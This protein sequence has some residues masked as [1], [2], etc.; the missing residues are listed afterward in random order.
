MSELKKA[1]EATGIAIRKYDATKARPIITDKGA[2]TIPKFTTDLVSA[3]GT[4]LMNHPAVVGAINSPSVMTQLIEDYVEGEGL[5]SKDSSGQISVPSSMAHLTLNIDRSSTEPGAK[6]FF[7][8]TQEEL[9]DQETSGQFYLD[10]CGAS[11][12][13]GVR[14]ARAVVPRYMP[15]R[16]RGTFIERHPVTGAQYTHFNT[17]VPSEWELWKLR[18][19]REWNKLPAKPPEEII[20]FLKHLIPS[21][22]ERE[23]LYA[24]IY[25]SM[26]SRSFVYLVLQG[27]PGV[28]K[29]RLNVLLRALHGK[30]NSVSGKKETFGA[31]DSRFNNQMLNNTMLWLD[32]LKYGPDMEPRMKEYQ[33]PYIAIERKG[34]DASS[35]TEIYSSMVISN[36][37]PRDNYILFN[38]RKFAPLVLGSQALTSSMT[39]EE[40]TR[41]SERMDNTFHTFDVKYVAQI[42]KWILHVGPKHVSKWPNLEY[43]GPKFW[44]LAHSSMSRWQKIAVLSLTTQTRSGMFAGWNPEKKAFLWSKVEEGLRRK[45]EYEAKDYR[46]ASTVKSFFDN[47]C[48]EKGVRIFETEEVPGSIIQ[49]FWVRP[50]VEPKPTEKSSSSVGGEKKEISEKNLKSDP[51]EKLKR[52]PGISSFHW[53]KMKYE[54]ELMQKGKISETKKEQSDL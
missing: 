47:Y 41:M 40:I 16:K 50:I 31:N 54:Y 48:D 27:S 22:V 4:G 6:R 34:I 19:P 12:S 8:T 45:K 17:Y 38:S 33:N 1:L 42:A 37:Y 29:N 53:R 21:K 30:S 10:S 5:A 26:T 3:L 32:E 51:T 52:P 11:I 18:N 39:P 9:M 46:D 35:S 24:W 23:Y 28:G 7:C 20:R 13:D 36:N 14:L 2:V 44:E 43:Q 49:D 15:R 25:T